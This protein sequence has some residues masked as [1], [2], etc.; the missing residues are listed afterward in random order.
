[1]NII[2]QDQNHI[3]IEPEDLPERPQHIIIESEELQDRQADFHLN[4]EDLPEK[5]PEAPLQICLYCHEPCK[6][7]ETLVKCKGCDSVYHQDHW[8]EFNGCGQL[9][10]RGVHHPELCQSIQ[11]NQGE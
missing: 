9:G 3:I 6:P 11:I 10:C 5:E 2:D 4:R 1:M 8:Y 7:G